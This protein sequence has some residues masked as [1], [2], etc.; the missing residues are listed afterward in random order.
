MPS[1]EDPGSRWAAEQ[2]QLAPLL[3]Q[4]LGEGQVAAAELKVNS[5]PFSAPPWVER[6][7]SW[8]RLS[9]KGVQKTQEA[10]RFSVVTRESFRQWKM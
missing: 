6:G 4:Q 2:S 10:R 7:T 5:Y 1:R 9:S 8:A 3:R